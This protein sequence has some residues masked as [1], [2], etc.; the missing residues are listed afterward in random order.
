MK[1]TVEQESAVLDIRF[2]AS[3]DVL[4]AA[5]STGT[6]TVYSLVDGQLQQIALLA[7]QSIDRQTLILQIQWLNN[8]L[9]CS[10]STG[11]VLRIMLSEAC[12]AIDDESEIAEM[13]S[14]YEV[15]AVYGREGLTASGDDGCCLTMLTDQVWRTNKLHAAGV[16]SITEAKDVL[17]TGSYDGRLRVIEHGRV[18]AERDL[19][20]GVWRLDWV[21]PG[22]LL[23]SA[24]H[25]GAFLVRVMRDSDARWVIELTAAYRE[26]QSMVYAGGALVRG[27]KAV[28]V[29]TSFYDQLV[30][31]WESELGGG[32]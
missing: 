9:L 8:A 24:M 10:T 15:W 29:S 28:V 32:T 4:V 27:G 25:A 6:L 20:G 2:H 26:H 17:L 7:P 31:V 3:K 18:V 16:T 5:S 30:C 13:K 14:D 12:D 1:Q 21:Y 11:K 19:G 22:L 23:V